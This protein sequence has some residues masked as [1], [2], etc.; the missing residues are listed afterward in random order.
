MRRSDSLAAL[1][2]RHRWAV[3]VFYHGIRKLAVTPVAHVL[4]GP[5]GR[6][7]RAAAHRR[8]GGTEPP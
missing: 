5:S 6:Q 4:H 7:E 2:V 3:E 8:E 1:A